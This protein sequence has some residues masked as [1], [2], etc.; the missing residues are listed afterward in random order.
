MHLGPSSLRSWLPPGILAS[1]RE[2]EIGLLRILSRA[3]R[4]DRPLVLVR[5]AIEPAPARAPERYGRFLTALSTELR[6]EDL[7]WWD[8]ESGALLMLLEDTD[9]CASFRR[10]LE[11][12]AGQ[13]GLQM[14]SR[15]A[16][17]PQQGC[18]LTALLEE[19]R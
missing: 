13:E 11:E 10:R 9:A 17:F 3:R 12:R 1:R 8:A 7:C 6:L 5:L 2:A 16:R 18:T 4:H 14:A 15:S 19:A